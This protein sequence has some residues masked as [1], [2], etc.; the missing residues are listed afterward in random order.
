MDDSNSDENVYERVCPGKE[1][2]DSSVFIAIATSLAAFSI[3]KAKD[4]KGREI[5]PLYE[6]TTG[7]IRY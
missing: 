4:D 6:Y 1:L 5:D 3:R 2:A 7:I